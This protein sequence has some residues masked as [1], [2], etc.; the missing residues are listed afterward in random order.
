MAFY[1]RRWT[2]FNDVNMGRN[3]LMNSQLNIYP[4]FSLSISLMMLIVPTFLSFSGYCLKGIN[5]WWHDF[6]LNLFSQYILWR[7]YSER[8]NRIQQ[9]FLIVKNLAKN[10]VVTMKIQSKMFELSFCQFQCS[11]GW[12]TPKFCSKYWVNCKY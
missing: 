10:P 3:I 12:D 4:V 6:S 7:F 5:C 2:Y 9:N 11:A 1:L 8:E